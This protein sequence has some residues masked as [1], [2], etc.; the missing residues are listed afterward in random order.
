MIK[1]IE[2]STHC[3]LILTIVK[4]FTLQNI[5][6]S[7][8]IA[9]YRR[10]TFRKFSEAAGIKGTFSRPGSVH[11]RKVELQQLSLVTF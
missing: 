2:A 11:W 6:G 10:A 7:L 3:A 5:E 1:S 8:G 4:W 9:R